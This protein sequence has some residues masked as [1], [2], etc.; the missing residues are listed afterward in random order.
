M[1][2]PGIYNDT[3]HLDKLP[4]LTIHDFESIKGQRKVEMRSRHQNHRF[5]QGVSFKFFF[6]LYISKNCFF[7]N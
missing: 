4:N 3:G 1:R 5:Y 6:R 7:R 2:T